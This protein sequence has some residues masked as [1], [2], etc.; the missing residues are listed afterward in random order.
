MKKVLYILGLLQDR[1]IEWMVAAGKRRVLRGGEVLVREGEPFNAIS[2]IVDGSVKVT[3]GA[4]AIASI[5][6][7]EVVGEIS[8]LDSRPPSATV[9]AEEETLVLSISVHD[10]RARLASD[11]GFA[12]R[13]Y[14][15]LGV[16][17]AQRLRRNNLQLTIG[18]SREIDDILDEMD[19]IDP[20]V[21]E[22]ITLAGNRFKLI[23]DKLQGG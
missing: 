10:L 19:E 20:E 6:S 1:D 7:G 22:Q 18:T 15:A 23:I 5:G 16:F 17:L 4:K 9:T 21:L 2:I 8:L 12:A 3:V 13:L 11:I 14:Q